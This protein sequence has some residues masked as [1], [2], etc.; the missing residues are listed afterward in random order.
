GQLQ[1][2]HN[3]RD[4]SITGP[5][6]YQDKLLL[7]TAGGKVAAYSLPESSAERPPPK[8]GDP[9]PIGGDKLP[10]GQP[11][12]AQIQERQEKAYFLDEITVG[13]AMEHWPLLSSAGLILSGTNN[14]LYRIGLSREGFREPVEL[15]L[16]GRLLRR[17]AQNGRMVYLA[18]G[19]EYVYAV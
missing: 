14:T 6:A 7:T 2:S 8:P 9:P 15:R 4:G 13:T 1:W 11:T 10:Y 18:C 5:V 16:G 3:L 19:D 12:L 17:P